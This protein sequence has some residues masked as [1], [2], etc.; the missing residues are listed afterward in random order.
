MD[1]TIRRNEICVI[2]LPRCDFVFSSTRTCFIAYGFQESPLEMTILRSLLDKRGIQ[3]VEAGG[4][5][6]PAQNA[7]CAKICSKIIMSQ[8]CIVLLNNEE[9][10]GIEIPNPNVN[11]EYGLMLGFNKYVIPFQRE[12]QKLPFNV[13]GLDTIKY[14]DRNFERLAKDAIDQAIQE[15]QQDTSPPIRPDQFLEAFLLTQKALIT[16]LNT[17]GDRAIFQ[18]GQ[19]LGFNLLNDFS[20]LSYMYLGNFTMLRPEIIAWR[21][22][23]LAEILDGRRAALARRVEAG[24]ATPEQA[25]M[26]EDVVARM[27]IWITVTTNEDKEKVEA[28]L[29]STCYAVRVFSVADIALELEKLGASRS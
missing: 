17:D 18:L 14:T 1:K 29:A 13:A 8:F 3:A 5:L 6:A 4:M 26:I 20:G 23:M 9:S 7:Y 24:M 28:A 16:P 22:Q 25:Q 27:H 21:V 2:G 12:S 19:P 11:M 10:N 15:T